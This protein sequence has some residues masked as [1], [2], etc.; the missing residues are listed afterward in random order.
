MTIAL[1]DGDILCF[2]A[3][4]SAEYS[5]YT[6][7]QEGVTFRYKK[8][9]DGYIKWN[10]DG[11]EAETLTVTVN[12]I[13]EPIGKAVL[14]LEQIIK[15]I[16]NHTGAPEYEVYISGEDN[17]RKKIEYP[18]VYKGNRVEPKPHYYHEM[19]KY[20]I[21]LHDAIVVD[22]MESDDMLSIR[23]R[24]LKGESII[25]SIDKDLKQVPGYHFNIDTK[26]IVKINALEGFRSF[27]KQMLM[28]DRTDN[29]IGLTG[30]GE[31]KATK[32]LADLKSEEEIYEAVKNAYKESLGDDWSKLFQANMSLIMLKSIR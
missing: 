25:C 11:D 21:E 28:G 32:T 6:L 14:A 12:K 7:V 29:I 16:L 30:Y 3:C 2:K 26:E 20:L 15:S 10:Y 31:V 1:V 17:F 13:V 4:F 22:G 24:E 19:R 9:V 27:G 23:Q 5:T 18:V 8:E